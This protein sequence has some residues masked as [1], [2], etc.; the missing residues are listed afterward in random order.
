MSL[1]AA[2]LLALGAGC[3][4]ESRPAQQPTTGGTSPTFESNVPPTGAEQG[5]Q[6]GAMG[7]QGAMGAQ[8]GAMGGQQGAM[9]GQQGAQPGT[10]G[11]PQGV[12]GAGATG[13]QQGAQPQAPMAGQ[14]ERE[15]CDTLASGAKLHVEDVQNGVAIVATPRAGSNLAT[16][17]DDAQRIERQIHQGP[18]AGAPGAGGEA[19]GLFSLARLPSV[20]TNVTEAANSVRIVMTTSNPSEVRDLRRVARD[21][22]NT[23]N[24]S[25]PGA[26]QRGGG[27]RG[28][29]GQRG[30]HPTQPGTQPR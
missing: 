15:M 22:I 16:V 11:A 17:R 12:P 14:S 28:G 20:S 7:E 8:P 1:G 3:S 23:I 27:Q 6:Q 30:Q 18:G 25:T 13:E 10:M 19:C 5:A 29:A 4:R 9:G 2:A 24:K 21:Q 26:Q